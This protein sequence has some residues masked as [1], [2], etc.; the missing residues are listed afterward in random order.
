MKS[1]YIF[2]Q[3]FIEL[4]SAI[5]PD[6]KSKQLFFLKSEAESLYLSWSIRC[7]SERSY[8]EESVRI[9]FTLYLTILIGILV[10]VKPFIDESNFFYV[11][12]STDITTIVYILFF[13]SQNH[14][15]LSEDLARMFIGLSKMFS[16]ILIAA[17][18]VMIIIINLG[19]IGFSLTELLKANAIFGVFLVLFGFILIGVFR[20]IP[21]VSSQV[22]MKFVF[23]SIKKSNNQQSDQFGHF[24]RYLCWPFS[25]LSLLHFVLLFY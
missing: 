22:V 19:G 17:N 4:R 21:Y 23:W 18:L 7:M 3:M 24:L 15:E 25:V 14:A 5:G 6:L 11:I 13:G 12:I 1:F 10:L 9:I 20:L 2:L 8:F 16:V